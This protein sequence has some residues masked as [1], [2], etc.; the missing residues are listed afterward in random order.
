MTLNWNT[1]MAIYTVHAPANFGTDLRAVADRIVFVRD[2]FYFWAFAASIVW[3]VWHRLWLALIGYIALSIGAEVLLRG[4]GAGADT[5]MLAM[6]IFACLVG[7]EAG[8][9]RRWKLSRGKWRELD[10][11]SAANEDE[12]ERRFFD[13]WRDGTAPFTDRVNSQRH[14]LPRSSI[15]GQDDVIGMFPQPGASR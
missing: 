7:L 15:S 11:V 6:L 5:R 1:T 3:L 9:L 12:A 4:L 14:P 8:S 2:G 10:V 13:R